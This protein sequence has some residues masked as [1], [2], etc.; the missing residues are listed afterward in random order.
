MIDI[1]RRIKIMRCI[2]FNILTVINGV[3]VPMMVFE[4]GISRRPN[5]PA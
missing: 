1:K 2:L 5:V 3:I 4:K